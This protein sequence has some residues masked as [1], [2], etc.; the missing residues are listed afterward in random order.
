MANCTKLVFTG[1]ACIISMVQY[2]FLVE[3]LELNTAG[4]EANWEAF[5]KVALVTRISIA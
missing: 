4:W 5:M 2:F 1:L 3:G